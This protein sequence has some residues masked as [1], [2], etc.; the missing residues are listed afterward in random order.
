MKPLTRTGAPIGSCSE[1]EYCVPLTCDLCK[2]EIPHSAA[3]TFE[4]SDYAVHFCGLGCL[5]TWKLHHFRDN[6]DFPASE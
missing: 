3:V 2:A 6:P 1:E 4:G 5:E